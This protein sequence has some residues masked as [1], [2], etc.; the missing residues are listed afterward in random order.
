MFPVMN[1]WGVFSLS[2]SMHSMSCEFCLHLVSSAFLPRV[3]LSKL[4]LNYGKEFILKEGFS[5]ELTYIN[6]LFDL[7]RG[8]NFDKVKLQ[9][10]PIC[11]L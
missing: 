10:M 6:Y 9:I 3:S 1:F 5:S 8:V 7:H 11:E 2:L 4:K